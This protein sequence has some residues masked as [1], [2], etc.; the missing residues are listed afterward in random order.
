M[1]ITFDPRNRLYTPQIAR[2]LRRAASSIDLGEAGAELAAV[3]ARLGLRVSPVLIKLWLLERWLGATADELA[4][5]CHRR[6]E[7]RG[8]IGAPPTGPIVDAWI[9]RQLATRLRAAHAE[10]ESLRVR[11]EQ[12][13]AAQGIE[14]PVAQY[15]APGPAIDPDACTPAATTRVDAAELSGVA[16]LPEGAQGSAP[17]FD[18]DPVPLSAQAKPRA[19]IIWPCGDTTTIDRLV[20]IGRD[21]SFSPFAYRVAANRGVSRR[22]ATLEPVTGGIM[23]RDLGSTNGT[24]RA[25]TLIPSG[26]AMLLPGDAEIRF[27]TTLAVK[28]VFFPAYAARSGAHI[29]ARPWHASAGIAHPQSN[30]VPA[31]L[32]SAAQYSRHG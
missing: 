26:D 32:S 8:F 28:I 21:A 19:I 7:L 17:C 25:D 4:D 3:E 24:Y 1:I 23:L 30:V 20:P 2:F 6:A 10:L 13:L 11:V 9:Y 12:R 22:H 16:T 31:G 18:S 5:S 15:S 27:G 29:R 14:A